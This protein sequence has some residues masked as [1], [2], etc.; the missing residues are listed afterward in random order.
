MPNGRMSSI[1]VSAS[2]SP[3][4]N[5]PAPLAALRYGLARLRGRLIT[6]QRKLP[7]VVLL[8]GLGITAAVSEQTRRLGKQHHEQIERAL[9]DDVADAIEVKLR[10]DIDT[11]TGVAGL[12]NASSEVSRQEFARYYQTLRRGD[13]S[14][15][16]I[17]GIGFSRFVSESDW[18]SVIE[19]TRAEGFADFSIRPPGP[20]PLGSA[21]VY[22]EPFDLRNQ[23]A[24]GYDMYS[25]A[26]RRQAMDGAAQSGLATMS[27]PVRLMQERSTGVQAG[28]LIYAPVY[29]QGTPMPPLDPSQYR[30]TL[31]GWAYS[32]IRVGDLVDAALRTVNNPD[33]AG[34]AVLVHDGARPS[35]T[36]VL[37][38]NQ[39]LTATSSLT[40]PQYQPIEVA[41]RTWLVGIQLTGQQIGPN[42]LS[43]QVLI[44]GVLGSMGSMIAALVTALLVNN[45]WTTRQAL[46]AAEKANRE[47]A[48]AATV[49]E[50]SPQA[51]VVTDPLGRVLSA[52]QSFARITGYAAAEIIGQ[53]L[54]LLKSGRHDDAFYARLW[55]D[56]NDQGFWQGDIWNRLRDGEIRRHELSITAVHDQNLQ[57]TNFVGMLQDITERHQAQE[58]IRHRALHDE[59]TGLP[60]RA[61]LLERLNA[62]LALAELQV[63]HVGLLFLDLDGFKPVNDRHGHAVG[64]R[65]LQLVARR[66]RGAI[67]AGDLVARMGGDEFVVLVP[68]AGELEELRACAQKIRNVIQACNEEFDTPIAISVSIGVA[69]SPEHGVTAGQLLAAADQ[70]MYRCKQTP[71]PG[72]VI[73]RHT[74]WS[75]SELAATNLDAG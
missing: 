33:L 66:L 10:E 25:D 38:D 1:G 16:G 34:S 59:L 24:F 75:E 50:T 19:A 53:S 6:G 11:I 55:H 39:G 48:L 30:K 42:G 52:N 8:L 41:G 27:G 65:V 17:L 70:A 20:R 58:V 67:Q 32:P 4:S 64:D 74:Q 36:T 9:L 13:D 45:H 49:F 5:K 29:R 71:G 54:R 73:A 43:S 44:A 63:S 69:R 22:L 28:V 15:A 2:A 46:E 26:T 37:H 14:L 61:M 68:R 40:H 7:L 47:R 12:F 23:R 18:R 31:V 72:I 62:A 60:A 56:V 51:I 3:A 21:I 35:A 57:I